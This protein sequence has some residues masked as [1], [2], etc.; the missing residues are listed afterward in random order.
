MNGAGG[1]Q[2]GVGNFLMG[3]A[4]MCG[5]FYMLLQSIKVTMSFGMGARL[6]GMS[7]FGQQVGI[8]SGMVMIPFIF[9]VGMLFYN[10]RNFIGWLLTLG[11]LAAMI[12]GV[13]AS[14]QFILKTMT[15]FELITILVLC[16][17]G[18]GL[19]LRSLKNFDQQTGQT[20]T[21]QTSS[22]GIIPGKR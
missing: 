10:G 13:I 6:F 11:S 9:G 16:V 8:T 5:G 3:L 12:F 17:G 20:S 15:A 7:M 22:S 21:G 18:L 14:T 19:F 4:M 1:T 2:G